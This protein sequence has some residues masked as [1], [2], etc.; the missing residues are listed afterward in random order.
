MDVSILGNRKTLLPKFSHPLVLVYDWISGPPM[1]NQE[2][3]NRAIQAAE[4]TR[5][6][7]ERCI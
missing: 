7:E 1:T 6:L 2:R 5:R 3:I 4:A